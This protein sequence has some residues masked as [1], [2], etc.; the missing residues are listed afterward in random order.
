MPLAN[1]S[2]TTIEKDVLKACERDGWNGAYWFPRVFR[3]MIR[4]PDC[5]AEQ[6]IQKA[7]LH[8]IDIQLIEV[9][10]WDGET[11]IAQSAMPEVLKDLRKNPG[12]D[13]FVRTRPDI[14]TVDS[15]LS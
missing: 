13:L 8:L 11:F 9:G 10:T 7:L 15:K 14:W 5:A 4:L 12:T 2:F 6:E 3:E 1:T